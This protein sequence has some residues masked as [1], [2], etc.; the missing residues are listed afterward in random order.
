VAISIGNEDLSSTFTQLG[1]NGGG[2]LG[3]LAFG[4]FGSYFSSL[5]IGA[6]RLTT[7]LHR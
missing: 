7:S 6:C 5:G 4:S 2:G 3:R 1:T